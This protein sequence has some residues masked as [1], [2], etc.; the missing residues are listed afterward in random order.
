MGR[1][2]RETPPAKG[3]LVSGSPRSYPVT[4]PSPERKSGGPIW[5]ADEFGAGRTLVVRD[6]DGPP[7]GRWPCPVVPFG[8]L[9]SWDEWR[10]DFG[11]RIS[12]AMGP[13][14][15]KGESLGQRTRGHSR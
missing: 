1:V 4:R 10:T 9:L 13:K 12:S 15:E 3:S 11:G 6:N 2:R 8:R 5:G 7:R 14:S